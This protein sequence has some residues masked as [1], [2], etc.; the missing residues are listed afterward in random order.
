MFC[1]V[2]VYV[3]VPIYNA[4]VTDGVKVGVFV[5]VGVLV[6]VKVRVAVDACALLHIHIKNVRNA[7]IIK[8]TFFNYTR[9]F[10]L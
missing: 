2:G 7:T 5:N 1:D 9:Q 8:T 6:C 10:F 4:G 3:F